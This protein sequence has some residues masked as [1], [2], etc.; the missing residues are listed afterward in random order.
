MVLY[1]CG[2]FIVLSLHKE[3]PNLILVNEPLISEVV[4]SHVDTWP[5]IF[6]S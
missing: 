6:I 3:S 5:H 1:A 2:V 4:L